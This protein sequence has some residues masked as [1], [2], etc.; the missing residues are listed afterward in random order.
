MS[1]LMGL[2]GRSKDRKRPATDRCMDCGMTDG[3]HTKWCPAP[4][5]ATQHGPPP[6]PMESGAGE[7]ENEAHPT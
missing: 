4:R 3:K 7:T 6:P 1:I 2:F 5:E